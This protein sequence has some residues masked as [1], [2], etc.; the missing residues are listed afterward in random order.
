MP[1]KGWVKNKMPNKVRNWKSQPLYDARKLLNAPANTQTR[2]AFFRTP[3]GQAEDGEN[4]STFRT[5]NTVAGQVPNKQAYVIQKIGVSILQEGS[6][7]ALTDAEELINGK[8]Y[9]QFRIRRE[10]YWEA[11]LFTI[12]SGHGLTVHAADG[13]AAAVTYMTLGHPSY[14]A[15][16]NVGNKTITIPHLTPFDVI[17]EYESAPTVTADTYLFVFFYGFMLEPVYK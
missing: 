1:G 15:M 16:Y 13:A 11:P 9:F 6:S 12:N 14:Q 17:I 8:A 2:F 3:Q 4:K 5:N 10:I 7:I